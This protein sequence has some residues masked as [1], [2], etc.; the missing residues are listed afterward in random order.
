[1]ARDLLKRGLI[2]LSIAAASGLGSGCASVLSTPSQKLK[3]GS[4][5]PGAKVSVNG[6]TKGVTPI[7]VKV[8]R[9]D[10]Q[11]VGLFAPGYDDY[12]V[13][14]DQN[15]NWLIWGNIICPPAI[16][17][18][19]GTGAAVKHV[20]SKVHVKLMKKGTTPPVKPPPMLKN[21]TIPKDKALVIFYRKRKMAG[22]AVPIVISEGPKMLGAVKGNRCFAVE[23]PPGRHVFD[24][25][26]HVHG[27]KAEVS[28]KAGRI[29]Y[30]RAELGG[31]LVAMPDW[32]AVK[33]LQRF[34]LP[35]KRR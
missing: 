2:L 4:T 24:G 1:M 28:L 19:M 12:Q 16:L 34:R 13:V 6:K 31:V 25:G 11:K 20:P 27:A 22:A 32:Q 15:L 33:E 29:Y 14:L 18:D 3:I 26:M 17:V 30:I 23:V 9:R 8:K 7:T 5:P 21:V 10:M 35:R